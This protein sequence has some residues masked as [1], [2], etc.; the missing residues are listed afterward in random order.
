MVTVS[1][2]K[3]LKPLAIFKKLLQKQFAVPYLKIVQCEAFIAYLL[4][5]SICRYYIMYPFQNESALHSC[6]NVK[7]LLPRNRCNI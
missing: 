1:V 5:K 4:K 2:M 3:E 6:L 7:E